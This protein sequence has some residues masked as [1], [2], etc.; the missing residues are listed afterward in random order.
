MNTAL[1]GLVITGGT[2]AAFFSLA[3]VAPLSAQSAPK[4]AQTRIAVDNLRGV[5]IVV[6]LDREPLDVRLGTVKPHTTGVLPLPEYLV[7]GEDARVFVHPEGG[8]D[9]ASQDVT[10]RKGETL[11][12]VVPTNEVGYLPPP[13]PETIPNP[14]EG[15]TTVTVKNPRS[16]PVV[17]FIENGPF[18][19]RIGTVPPDQETTLMIPKSLAESRSDIEIFLHPEHGLD[20]A[21]QH[22]ELKPGDHLLVKVPMP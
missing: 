16:V 21:S 1:R 15:T 19:S 2:A 10:I 5:P 18:D 9:L 11:N 8:Q 22:F 14:G 3:P 17:V 12:V 20:L 7:N 13:P 6:Y 4:D